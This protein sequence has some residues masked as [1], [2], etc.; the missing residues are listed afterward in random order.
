MPP[1]NGGDG[2]RYHSG[3]NPMPSTAAAWIDS[4]RLLDRFLRYVQ[5][6]TTAD[7]DTDQYPSTEGQRRLGR[8]LAEE[9]RQMGLSDVNQDEYGLVHATLPANHPDHRS[10][11]GIALVAHMD[12]SPEAPG[13]NVRPRVIKDYDNDPIVLSGGGV[14]RPS[15]V[16]PDV[17]W[18]GKTLVVTDGTTLLGGDDKCGVAIIMQF[19]ETMIRQPHLPRGPIEILMTCDEEIGR[20]TDKIN[21]GGLTS[22]VGYTIDG[23]G[24]GVIDVETFSAD[25][26]TVTFVGRNIH[27]A[28]AKGEMINAA[29]IASRFIGNLPRDEMSP[30]TTDGRDGFIHP[31]TVTG[32]VGETSVQLILRSF[33]ESQLDALADVVI[34]AA[35]DAAAAVTAG[36]HSASVQIVR[37]RQY[38]NLAEGLAKIPEA[39]EF[40]ERALERLGRSYRR[41]IVR[42]GTD[43]SLLTEKGLP[44]P[45]LSSGQYNI[46]STEEFACLDDMVEA[47]EHLVVLAEQWAQRG[48]A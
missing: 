46:H 26:M 47:T 24:R 20:G 28:I 16:D 6:E 42:G 34:R 2:C 4:D 8:M 21:V 14:I 5:V 3:M 15:S 35:E 11:A 17:D 41:E 45:N 37:R 38:R 18:T 22:V 43:G 40:A 1:A 30:E 36:D 44:T 7:P 48:M 19:V 31:H 39:V 29:K 33:E 27:P 32:G 12:T 25:A 10:A 9:L 13:A 23:G